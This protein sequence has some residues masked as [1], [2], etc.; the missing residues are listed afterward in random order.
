MTHTQGRRLHDGRTV[1]VHRNGGLRK[2]CRCSRRVWAK[3]PH[4]WHLNF[5][6]RSKDY[7]FSLDRYAGRH[8]ESKSE[9]DAFAERIRTEIRDGCFG[10]PQ[11]PSESLTQ[12]DITFERFGEI[13]LNSYSK[14]RE[15]ASWEDDAWMIRTIMTYPLPANGTGRLGEKPFSKVI[16]ADLEAF[17][18]HLAR[19]GRTVATRNHFVGILKTMSGW[20]VRK[21]YRNSQLV[22]GDSDVIRRRKAR[23][24]NRRLEPGEEDKLLRATGPHLQRI[25]IAALETCCRLGELLQLQWRDLSLAR[26]EILLRAEKTKTRTDRIIPIST[27]LRGVLEMARHDPAGQQFG[28]TAYV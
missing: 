10:K 22:S 3:C 4:P 28:P 27:R 9:A 26:G 23:R 13:F 2:I 1:A 15:K 6:W 16:E 12:T 5:R 7:R 24:R 11:T 18:T 14:A 17:I 21:G 25:I 20:A 19:A 8:L